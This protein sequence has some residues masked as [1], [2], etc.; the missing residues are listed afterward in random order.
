MGIER[1]FGLG[2]G[3][4]GLHHLDAALVHFLTRQADQQAKFL[5]HAQVPWEAG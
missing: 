4:D 2:T 5:L 3:R 1:R